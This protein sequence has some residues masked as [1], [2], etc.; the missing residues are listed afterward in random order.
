MIKRRGKF[1]CDTQHLKSEEQFLH[2]LFCF[3]RGKDT[4]LEGLQADARLGNA[5]IPPYDKIIHKT[6]YGT[7]KYVFAVYYSVSKQHI[8]HM[9]TNPTLTPPPN[10]SLPPSPSLNLPLSPSLPPSPSLPLALALT[11]PLTLAFPLSLALTYTS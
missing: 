7:L 10:P 9:H 5:T 8:I 1:T 2:T 11:F 4:S 3:I 6:K